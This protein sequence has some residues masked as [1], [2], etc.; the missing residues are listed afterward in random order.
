M[1]AKEFNELLEQTGIRQV[2]LVDEFGDNQT[3]LSHYLNGR[4]D[5]PEDFIG[6]RLRWIAKVTAERA[7]Y[8]RMAEQRFAVSGKELALAGA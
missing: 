7:E 1:T 5:I 3:M 8:A 6:P 2:D 4:K